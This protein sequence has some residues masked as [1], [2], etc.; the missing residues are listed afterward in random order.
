MGVGDV[1]EVER[2]SPKLNV[3]CAL[4]MNEVIGLYFFEANIITSEYYLTML[5]ELGAAK[6]QMTMGVESGWTGWTPP[7]VGKLGDVPHNNTAIVI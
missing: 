5:Q 6:Y 7:P 4:P 2:D 1:R 3:W